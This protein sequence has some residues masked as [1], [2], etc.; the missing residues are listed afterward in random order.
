MTQAHLHLM[1]NHVPVLATVTGALILTVALIRG[2]RGAV[3]VSLWFF[4]AAALVAVPV[5]LSGEGAEEV[6]EALDLAGEPVVEAH[7]EMA[8]W[9]FVATLLLGLL[10]GASLAFEGVASGADAGA[11]GSRGARNRSDAPVRRW[12]ERGTWVLS[13]AAAVLMGWTAYLGGQINHPEI[14]PGS[15]VPTQVEET[16]EADTR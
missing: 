9:G 11:Q 1:L 13:V 5:F 10:A 14:R 6:I 3:R 12:L 15:E 4:V 16:E 7:E 2:H 8:L